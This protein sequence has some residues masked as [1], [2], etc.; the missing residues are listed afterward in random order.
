MYNSIRFR[1]AFD[2]I[3]IDEDRIFDIIRERKPRY[4]ALNGPEPLLPKIQKVSEK[5]ENEFNIISYIIG[6][7]SCGF[8]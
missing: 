6:E 7:K 1:K 8:L 2:L 4:V 3:Q 5:I